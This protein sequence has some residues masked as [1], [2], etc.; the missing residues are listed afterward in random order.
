MKLKLM[1]FLKNKEFWI[2]F[3]IILGGLFLRLYRISDLFHYT[4]DEEVMNL[5]QRRIVLLQ[6]FPLIGSVSPL[7]TYLGPIFY[8][9]GATIL[10]LSNLNPLGLGIFAAILGGLNIF[11]IY[12]IGKRLFSTKVGV[13]ASI[14]YASSFLMVIFDR[15]YWHLTP[16][17]MLSLIVL[18]SIYKIKAGSIK[19]IY[20]LT[21][22]L[23][24]GWNTDYTNLV[25]FLF[26]FLAWLIFKLPV[27]RKEV[28]IAILI[29]IISNAPLALFEL[30][31]DFLNSKAFVNYFLLKSSVKKDLEGIRHVEDR[32]TI[33]STK[34]EQ[35]LQT[36][37]LPF[38]TFSRA[39][40]I[41]SN[42]NIA[43][44]QTYCRPYILERNRNQ[45]LILPLIAGIVI[46]IFFIITVNRR[47]NIQKFPCQLLLSFYMIFQLGVLIYAYIFKGDVFE[48]Y[49]ATLLPYFFLI[50][51]VVIYEVIYRK[52]PLF[53]Y[54]LVTL[55]VVANLWLNYQSYN[56]LGYS[57][58]IMATKFALDRIGEKEFSLDAIG[59]CFRYDGFYYPFLLFN[60]HPVKSFQDPNYS[61][62]FNYQIPDKHPDRVVVMVANGRYDDETLRNIYSRYQQWV[63]DRSKY[64][65]LEVLILDNSKG[66]FR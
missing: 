52:S 5:I 4:M 42:L 29:F 62:L 53:T 35:A 20:L 36:I 8:Y 31:H 64:G 3:F 10:G 27:R 16:G 40:Y 41:N 33:G 11:L 43:E 49:L 59:S 50:L 24:L 28:F 22:A 39:L 18:W 34:E 26:T 54:I 14:F 2:V 30:R 25:L 57:N 61:W 7:S 46:L 6:H 48:H 32:E 12:F 58:K 44:Q 37:L 38:I 13:F 60:R 23:I 66:D 55:F 63:I 65:D 51:A 45:G 1:P 15:R 47:K 9:F 19:Y 21:A 17:P 56:G